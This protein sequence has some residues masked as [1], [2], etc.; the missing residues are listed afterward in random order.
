[1]F[2]HFL[3]IIFKISTSKRSK[4]YKP[5]Q[6]LA[7]KKIQIFWERELNHIPKRSLIKLAYKLFNLWDFS[8]AYYKL[9][10]R[11]LYILGSLETYIIINFKIPKIY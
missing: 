2:F 4:K 11:V 6:I 3:K 1:M 7:K 5:Y 8:F 9:P 10:V